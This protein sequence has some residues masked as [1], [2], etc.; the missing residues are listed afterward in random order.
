MPRIV[1]VR[2]YGGE[3]LARE[4][5]GCGKGVI[6]VRSMRSNISENHDFPPAIGVPCHDVFAYNE[7]LFEKLRRR[8]K[9][10]MGIKNKEWGE[11]VKV[12]EPANSD[13]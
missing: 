8:W 1:L 13:T 2:A 5:V 7:A 12:Q 4:A 9:A 10:G 6:Y 11:P 3:P